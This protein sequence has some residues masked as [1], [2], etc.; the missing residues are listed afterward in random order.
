MSSVTALVPIKHHSQRVPEKN[1]RLMAG[2]PLFHHI[3]ERLKKVPAIEQIVVNTDSPVI[4]EGLLDH[5]PAVRILDRPKELRGDEVS[6]NKIISYDL[7]QLQSDIFLQTHTTNPMLRPESI[8]QA[9]ETYFSHLS[10]YDSL[11]SVTR[12]YTR[13]WDENGHAIN[14]DPGELIQTQNLPPVYEENSCM[15][16]FSRASFQ[17]NSNRLGRQP[18]LFEIDKRESWDIDT[19][20]DFHIVS[21]LMSGQ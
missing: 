2:K 12:V 3:L 20:L 17:K 13:L 21:T 19:E 14:H 5:F 18:Y 16:I 9:I 6:M 4:K 1:Y 8:S 10:D 11:F 15:Y 7:S